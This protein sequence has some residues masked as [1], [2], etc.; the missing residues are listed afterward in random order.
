MIPKT[1]DRAASTVFQLRPIARAVLG[2]FLGGAAFPGHALPTGAEVS[3]GNGVISRTGSALT[4][5]QTS[6]RLA[7]NWQSFG[8]GA[9]E[10]VIFRQPDA[11]AI[12]LNRVL[13]Q[14]PSVILGSLSANG[15]VFVLNPNGVL[16][17][18]GA[19]VDVGGI[20]ASTLGLSDADFLAGRYTFGNGGGT[21]SVVNRGTIRAAD[22]GYV[23]LLAPQVVNEGVIAARLGTVALGAGNQVTLT[24]AGNALV[25]FSVD[26]AAV[27]ALAANKQLIQADGGTVILSAQAKDALLSTVVNN[28]GII[29]ARSVSAKNGVIRLEG[30]AS[31]VVAVSGRLDASGA[32]AGETGG[33]VTITGNKVGLM[34]GA[35][36][37]A[38]GH[39]AGGT[40]QL[41]GD[42][43]GRNPGVQN[44]SRTYVGPDATIRVDAT[45]QGDGGRAIVWADDATRFRGTISARGGANGGAGGFIEVS[46]KR[47]LDF[48]G[49]VDTSATRGATG[50]LLLDPSDITISSALDSGI[51]AGPNFTGTA[52]ASNLRVST[53]Q[54]ALASNNVLVD[55]SS[56]FAS[57]GNITVS[58][59]VTWAS[60]TSLTLRANNS[61]NVNAAVS[62]TGAGG[63]IA[64]IADQD[65]SGAGNVL[66]SAALSAAGGTI[67]VT[68]VNVI[69]LAAGS[70]TSTGP[71]TARGE[72]SRSAL[73]ATSVWPAPLR[74]TAGLRPEPIPAALRAR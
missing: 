41:G 26:Q 9:A 53:L 42:Y 36:V 19:Q 64:L 31:G 56:A 44:A 6:P 66:L 21:G 17:G 54:T 8:I 32:N 72:P 38:S 1:P 71:P 62:A 28:E 45:E 68:G 10:S 25:G 51:S 50:T 70:I 52:A 39:S 58:N 20:V 4:V 59:A 67:G 16:F 49:R 65:I 7:I 35:M 14:D 55:T 63:S 47:S 69:S 34:D 3:A 73:P 18:P 15:Q 60:P 33:T 57:A 5:Q 24:L 37:D 2:L 13:G 27:D 40:V 11:S 48:D 23:A 74:P 30:G 22:G 43:Q 61:I 29:E 12:A 46:G